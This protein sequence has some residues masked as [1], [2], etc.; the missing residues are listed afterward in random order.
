MNIMNVTITSPL[1]KH[2][3][4]AIVPVYQS[5]L[6]Y[7]ER[8]SLEQNRKILIEYPFIFIRPKGLDI[9][10]LLHDFPDC[11]EEIFPKEY[12]Q[13]IEGYNRLMMSPDFYKRFSDKEYILICQLD[14]YIFRDELNEWC[15]K[16][17]DYIGAP[18][19]VSKIFRI[20]P[21]KQWR[22][23]THNKL[24]TQKNFK[25]GNG[26]LSLRKV[27]SHLKATEQLK[28]VI[29]T[30]LS[31]KF[32][33]C[34]EDLFFALEVNKHGMNF[35]Y[36]DYKEALHF[37]FDRHPDLCYKDCRYHLPFGCHAWYKGK[38]KDFWIPRIL[39][40]L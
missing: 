5:T 31:R 21:F 27:E 14:A 35:S 30:H 37:S 9:T 26:G 18:W 4:A 10:H 28:D 3:V 1:P 39:G 36:P 24:R 20:P 32:P 29:R 8:I 19:T 7:Y 40:R 11:K 13:G 22:K 23:L 15:S 16:G 17:Y 38:M 12:F 33:Y 34:N 25:V 2:N 6:E